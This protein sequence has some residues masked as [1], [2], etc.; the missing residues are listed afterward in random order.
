MRVVLQHEQVGPLARD[1]EGSRHLYG[2]SCL[3]AREPSYRTGLETKEPVLGPYPPLLRVHAQGSRRCPACSRDHQGRQPRDAAQAARLGRRD[4]FLKVMNH[5]SPFSEL[6]TAQRSYSET[7]IH[8]IGSAGHHTHPLPMI[9]GCAPGTCGE[10]PK[11]GCSH[12]LVVARFI[13][14]RMSLGGQERRAMNR[15]TQTFGHVSA[16]AFRLAVCRRSES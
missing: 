5:G 15:P 11:K 12:R 16:D 1:T 2:L 7:P 14:R 13:E 3:S 8:A 6:T 9:F 10:A 4:Q